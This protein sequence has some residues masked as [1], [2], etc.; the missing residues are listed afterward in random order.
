[1]LF[2]ASVTNLFKTQKKKALLATRKI[3]HILSH[4]LTGRRK[5]HNYSKNIEPTQFY[6]PI[7]FVQP[8]NFF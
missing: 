6:S 7:N 3:S 5:P 2:H 8:K 4:T 1:M